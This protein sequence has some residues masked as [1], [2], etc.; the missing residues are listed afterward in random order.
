MEDLKIDKK[1][2]IA[3]IMVASAV[4][5]LIVAD[6][7]LKK[8]AFFVPEQPGQSAE[9]TAEERQLRELEALRK[10]APPLTEEETQ[11][12]LEELEKLRQQR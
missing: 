6:A 1:F 4:F 2:F 12:Q 7:S 9:E 5:L 8:E 11:K 3:I 10:A